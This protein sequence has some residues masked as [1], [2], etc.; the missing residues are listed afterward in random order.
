MSRYCQHCG[1]VL[2]ELILED[3]RT[4]AQCGRCGEI[5]WR[6]PAPVGMALIA[7]EGGLVLIRRLADPLAG[8]W[9]PPAGYVESG[10]SVPG[11]VIREA[12]EETGLEIALD[13]LYEVYSRAD[14]NVLIVAYRAR[15]VSG[16]PV[17][18][19]D[20]IEIGLFAPGALPQE[21]P[22]SS[23]AAIDEWLYGVILDA[24]APWRPEGSTL[25]V[26]RD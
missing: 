8:Y 2:T 11:A 14:V 16:T 17:A 1:A 23:G 20:A 18:G 12:R 15:V 19:D 9:A 7:H 21:A 22:P 3:G 6:N 24:T 4:R 5:A 10:E 25:G 26:R 13:G